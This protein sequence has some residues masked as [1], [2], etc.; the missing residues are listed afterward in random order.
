M[1]GATAKVI[2]F[3]G[4]GDELMQHAIE[5][6]MV[7]ADAAR[8]YKQVL[9]E[10]QHLRRENR[11]L[12]RQLAAAQESRRIERRCKATAYRMALDI[13]N[14]R[15]QRRVS[16]ALLICVFALGGLAVA[17]LTTAVCLR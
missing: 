1:S 10:V 9:A 12:K 15:G 5:S 7:S 8:A 16:L 4:S 17:L 11:E 13:A 2:R 14:E 3:S 6:G